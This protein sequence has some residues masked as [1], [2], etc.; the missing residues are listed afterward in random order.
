MKLRFQL[1]LT[2]VTAPDDDA[3]ARWLKMFQIGDCR[4]EFEGFHVEI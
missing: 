1:I 4:L 3:D 2:D